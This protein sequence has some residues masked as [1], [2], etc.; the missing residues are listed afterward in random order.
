V[1]WLLVLLAISACRATTTEPVSQ[2][3]SQLPVET[4]K[5]IPY[6]SLRSLD[7][8]HPVQEGA[9]PVVVAYHGGNTP[10]SSFQALGTAIAS[11]GAVVFTPEWRSSP[12]S[13]DDITIGWEDAA[14][15]LRFAVAYAAEHGYSQDRLMVIG[16]SAGAAGGAVAMLAG[17]ELPGDCLA[18]EV[19]ADVDAFIGL[20]GAYSI[21]NY[22]PEELLAQGDPDEWARISPFT[23]LDSAHFRHGL[24]FHL[25]VGR[26]VE[27]QEDADRFETALRAVGYEAQTTLMPGMG[28]LQILA[29]HAEILEAVR[30]ML[31]AD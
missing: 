21:L 17:A 22:T 20:D 4:Q 14:C 3:E 5:Q 11:M 13:P 24:A 7:L 10:K 29:P 18:T 12:P 30:V 27:L 26:E 1:V 23:Y 25:F 19:T 8:Y 2:A 31:F 9:W 28:H 6:T 16:H 15:A